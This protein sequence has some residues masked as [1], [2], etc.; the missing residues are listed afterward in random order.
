MGNNN[1]Q[2]LDDVKVY[3]KKKLCNL[4]QIVQT[5]N[6]NHITRLLVENRVLRKLKSIKKTIRKYK[7]LDRAGSTI[8]LFGSILTPALISI[9]HFS[10]GTLFW[11]TFS[12]S[13]VTSIT[14][15]F[16]NTFDIKKK[17]L[18]SM[19]AYN[20]L[21]TETYSFFELSHN[22]KIYNNYNDAHKAFFEN[23]EIIIKEY[24]KDKINTEEDQFN[25]KLEQSK[26]YPLQSDVN[27]ET[28]VS[29]KSNGDTLFKNIPAGIVKDPEHKQSQHPSDNGETSLQG[30]FVPAQRNISIINKKDFFLRQLTKNTNITPNNIE[31][32]DFKSPPIKSN[33]GVSTIYPKTY[34][35]PRV[36]TP[37][38][39]KPKVLTVNTGS[40]EEN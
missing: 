31:N 9:Q 13:L 8:I 35:T 28:L 15:A 16:L 11:V 7:R 24:S 22:Y 5:L 37:T 12:T 4:I 38:L 39:D 32:K 29:K 14:Q 19:K 21:D 6:I 36:R 18:I 26:G 1:S 25:H 3:E 30:N 23:I 34:N 10:T 40:P 20:K 33:Y 17:V 27:T 2:I